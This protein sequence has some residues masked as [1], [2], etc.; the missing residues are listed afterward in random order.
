MLLSGLKK[1]AIYML[2]H[3]TISIKSFRKTERTA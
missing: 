2:T 1:V 3:N